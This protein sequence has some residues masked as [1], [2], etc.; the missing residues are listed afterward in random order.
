M[1]WITDADSNPVNLYGLSY[2]G[3]VSGE[4]R[5]RFTGSD[6][7]CVLLRGNA[8]E[9]GKRRDDILLKLRELQRNVH[10]ID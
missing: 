10:I 2:I 7:Y 1:Y 6:N 9:L 3:P 4:L 5:G 8:T